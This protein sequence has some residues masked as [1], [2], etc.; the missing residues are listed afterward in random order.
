MMKNDINTEIREV[1]H[2]LQ[3]GW[4]VPID[5]VKFIVVDKEECNCVDSLLNK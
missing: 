5:S 1:G 2:N 3:G 4:L